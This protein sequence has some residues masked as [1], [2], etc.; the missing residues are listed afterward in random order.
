MRTGLPS[1]T[2]AD[3]TVLDLSRLLPGPFCTWM[4]ADLGAR[5]WKVESPSGGDYARWYPPLVDNRDGGYG[6]FF[7][8]VNRG[9]QSIAVDLKDDRSAA[10]MEGLVRCADVLIEGFRPGVMER[11]GL[12]ESQ[13][14][15]WRPDLVYCRLSGFGQT[16]PDAKRAGHD[17]GYLARSGVL[18]A[19]GP[20]ADPPVMPAV[21]VADLAGGAL[22]AAFGI[23]SA[24]WRRERT[25]EGCTL[26]VSMTEGALHLLAPML[27]TARSQSR[28]VRR[29]REM[30]TGGLPC[31]RTYRTADDRYL[32]VAALEPHFW[33]AFCARIG[34][35]EWAAS[36]LA[37]GEEGEEVAAALAEVIASRPLAEWLE[38]LREDDVCVEP[39]L[40][41]DELV[42]DAQLVARNALHP[43]TG[44]PRLPVG[45]R[46]SA[47]GEVPPLLGE[48]TRAVLEEVGLSAAEIGT[49]LKAGVVAEVV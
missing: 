1:T 7:A 23:A 9:K 29:G 32:A 2:F 16:G 33:A 44:L 26:D 38:E 40:E 27:G 8:S 49:L 47:A 34:H 15:I 18:G 17:L 3:V 39:V 25:G 10:V 13:L 42:Q 28:P 5:I 11:L 43:A 31:Y 4:L 14:R 6:A 45:T 22:Q 37:Q 30:L 46:D 41:L 24:L 21:Q 20:S 36:G 12:D 19:T 48:H 35:P